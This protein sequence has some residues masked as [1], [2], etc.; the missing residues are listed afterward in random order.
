MARLKRGLIIAFAICLFL[1]GMASVWT[2]LPL[3]AILMTFATFLLIAN[4]RN[5]RALVRRIRRKWSFVDRQMWWFE[6]RSQARMVRVL[7][8][9]R[10]IEARLARR[11]S[12]F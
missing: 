5:G 4:T 3:G 7:K 2:P 12:S 6:D 8:T 10:P 1:I 9:T 11:S